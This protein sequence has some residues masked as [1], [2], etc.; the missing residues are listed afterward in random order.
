MENSLLWA[1]LVAVSS[2]V[3]FAVMSNFV[4]DEQI[5]KERIENMDIRWT[6]D[7]DEK[8]PAPAFN[9]MDNEECEDAVRKYH[10][11]AQDALMIKTINEK[12]LDD[13]FKEILDAQR[14][15]RVEL[16]DN[17]AFLDWIVS[18]WD[19]TWEA[20]NNPEAKKPDPHEDWS[21]RYQFVSS[22]NG[23]GKKYLRSE[24]AVEEAVQAVYWYRVGRGLE[25]SVHGGYYYYPYYDIEDGDDTEVFE[26]AAE[27]QEETEEAV[28]E[29][30]A[31]PADGPTAGSLQTNLAE[32]EAGIAALAVKR[33]KGGISE[34]AYNRKWHEEV[35]YEEYAMC[36]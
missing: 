14:R 32:N 21:M 26:E 19:Q 2:T 10:I 18:D 28:E 33:G 16:V 36:S 35:D 15:L 27:E 11:W 4:P 25:D 31:I 22:P 20:R 3:M 24:Q 13:S 29:L 30:V 7:Y 12:R 17:E 1:G 9:I 5:D 23:G 6:A 8:P 34:E